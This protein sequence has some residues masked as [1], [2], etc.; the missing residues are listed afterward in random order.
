MNQFSQQNTHCRTAFWQNSSLGDPNS[1]LVIKIAFHVPCYMMV[2]FY[3]AFMVL[4]QIACEI[5]RKKLLF[6]ER[7]LTQP[8]VLFAIFKMFSSR[9]DS[10]HDLQIESIGVSPS[11]FQALKSIT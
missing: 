8:N 4:T 9:M 10:F 11:I 2:C 3:Y 1:I 5:D 6:P 7:L